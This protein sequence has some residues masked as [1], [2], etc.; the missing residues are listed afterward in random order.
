MM[1]SVAAGVAPSSGFR[2][3][4][5]ERKR[6]TLRLPSTSVLAFVLTAKLP[7]AMHGP[8]VRVPETGC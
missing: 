4:G 7:V 8:N 5:F 1:F 3:V 2:P 6:V